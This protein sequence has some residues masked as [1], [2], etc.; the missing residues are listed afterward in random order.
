MCIA[1]RVPKPGRF[2][3]DPAMAAVAVALLPKRQ[4]CSVRN[5]I[6]YV[7]FNLALIGLGTYSLKKIIRRR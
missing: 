7:L 6:F 5:L 4:A 2:Q 3:A 1:S